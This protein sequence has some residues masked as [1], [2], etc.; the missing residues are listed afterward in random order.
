MSSKAEQM[1]LVTPVHGFIH[2]SWWHVYSR[3]MKHGELESLLLVSLNDNLLH[4]LAL[5]LNQVST[6]Q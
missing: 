3:Q 6:C 4:A 1:S 5:A 2:L